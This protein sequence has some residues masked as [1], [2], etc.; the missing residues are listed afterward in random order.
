MDDGVDGGQLSGGQGGAVGDG[1]DGLLDAGVAV[2]GLG[3]GGEAGEGDEGG[4]DCHQ[5]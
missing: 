2:R 1:G 4:D 3:L 5:E